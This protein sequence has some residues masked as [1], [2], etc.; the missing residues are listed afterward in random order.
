MSKED[1]GAQAR[2]VAL[3]PAL[4][5]EAV[6][7]DIETTGLTDSDSIT[8][9]CVCGKDWRKAWVEPINV[10]EVCSI[11][12]RAPQ[13]AA[14]NGGSF[15]IPFMQRAWALSDTQVG[16]WM[17]KLV[18]PL[19]VVRGVF[20]TQQCVKLQSVLLRNGLEGKSGSGA[21]AV[22]LARE[23]RFQELVLY[24]EQDTQQCL[25]LMRKKQ[26]L[27]TDEITLNCDDAEH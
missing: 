17:A 23:Q 4:D 27:W 5:P 2:E 1:R 6:A 10:F 22:V 19:Y 21:D 24:C 13:I 16:L 9:V 20:G 14:F 12:N 15:D 8:C 18:D 26:I 25:D 11:L 7:L 3:L